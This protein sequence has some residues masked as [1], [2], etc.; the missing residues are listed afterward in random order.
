MREENCAR[1]QENGKK[2]RNERGKV[3]KEIRKR[4][5]NKDKERRMK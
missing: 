4:K 2:E 5:K 3:H 1:K